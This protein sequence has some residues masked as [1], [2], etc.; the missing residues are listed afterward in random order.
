MSQVRDNLDADYTA[1]YGYVT[2]SPLVGTITFK[3]ST[4]P[5]LTTTKSFDFLNRL[6][7][8]NSVASGE[9]LPVSHTYAYNTA[10]Q[11]TRMTLVDGSYWVYAYDALGQ[12]TS[13]MKYWSDGTPV[14]GQQFAYGH[15][16][17]GNRTSTLAGGDENGA[18]LRAASY[19]VNSKNQYTSRDVPPYL[20][21]LGIAK[22]DATVTVQGSASGVSRRGEYFRKE[23]NVNNAS[24]AQYP[25]IEVDTD[26]TD[27]VSGKKYL[28]L[29]PESFTHDADGNLTQDG[30]WT[31]TW[32]AE[33]RL[34]KQERNVASPSGA[35]QKLEFEYDWQ[36][37]RIR[38]QFFTHSG[39][40]WMRQRDTVYLYD[41]WNL[42]AELNASSSNAKVRTYIWGLDLS[43]TMQ[44]AGGVGGLLMVI[45]H[46]GTTK[47]H[48]VAYDGNGNVMALADSTTGN[49]SARYEYGPFGEPIR[50]SG[51]LAYANPM[52]W[53]TKY[54]DGESGLV[55]YGYRSY[56]PS[57]G[58]WPNRDP[59]GERGGMNLYGFVRNGPIAYV[60]TD[61][62]SL[63]GDSLN[64]E[65]C[66]ANLQ[67]ALQKCKAA[68]QSAISGCKSCASDVGDWL[69]GAGENAAF[70]KDWAC[71]TGSTNRFYKDGD[72]LTESF[73][74]SHG[75]K[76]AL[77][78]YKKKNCPATFPIS[79]GTLQGYK[80]CFFDGGILNQSEVQ[81]GGFRG[82]ITKVDE[83]TI[84]IHISNDAS[85][86]S[87]F[88]QPTLSGWY[89]AGAGKLE[90]G[91]D[92]L[93]GCLPN[94]VPRIPE[95]DIPT[96]P[97][98]PIH[99]R[100]D[101]SCGG[102]IHQEFNFTMPNPCCK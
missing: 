43:G 96:W 67:A 79:Y 58:R 35:R 63:F 5:R 81:I 16:T 68:G 31:Y 39:S 99:S 93:N 27:P 24:A 4:N 32:D 28:P 11:R 17:I 56:N 97:V 40:K 94:P 21:V 71:N 29:H 54:T 45:D 7:S 12:V 52:R 36:G 75:I 98:W 72:R 33:N 15:D 62:R 64:Y 20:E 57:T 83:K 60:D 13:G 44:G 92:W 84:K 100:E 50:V 87:F 46:T 70:F 88:G 91:I 1:D 85:L 47:R 6:R 95:L 55:Y 22:V 65:A 37:R 34:I 41:G 25:T 78:E 26:V 102:N 86:R 3:E 9:T 74:Q 59:I 82:T 73:K 101:V 61:G 76:Q 42:I 80:D 38:K 14:A 77:E 69:Q 89:N 90:G 51:D 48:Y 30:R 8:I 49:W 23:L 2:D 53:S 18:D 10:N 19:S 66:K